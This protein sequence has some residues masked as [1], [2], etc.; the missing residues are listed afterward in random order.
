MNYS[1]TFEF[2]K[3]IC[4]SIKVWGK[5]NVCG[6]RWK[7]K[8]ELSEKLIKTKWKKDMKLKKKESEL[9]G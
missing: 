2:C 7:E 5:K 1:C 9:F 6:E 4:R 3:C 8:Q